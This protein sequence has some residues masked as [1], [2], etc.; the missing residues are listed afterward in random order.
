MCAH[1]PLIQQCYEAAVIIALFKGR[2]TEAQG[3]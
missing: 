3:T 1:T 2:E